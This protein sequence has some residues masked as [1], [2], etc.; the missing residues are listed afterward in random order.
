MLSEEQ[1]YDF[2]EKQDDFE[3]A[4]DFLSILSQQVLDLEVHWDVIQN[5]LYK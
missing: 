5:F 2:L 4:L 1:I 3:S